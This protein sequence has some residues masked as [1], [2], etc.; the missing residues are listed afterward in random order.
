MP[1]FKP[2][3]TKEYDEWIGQYGWS[4]EKAGT[5]Y[6]LLNKEG[7]RVCTINFLHGRKEILL[8]M[9]RRPKKPL[10]IEDYY[11]EKVTQSEKKLSSLCG[12][13]G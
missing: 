1:P 4:Y 10:K 8:S 11:H 6:D 3:R 9:S 13:A 12:E 2:M 5:D 7:K